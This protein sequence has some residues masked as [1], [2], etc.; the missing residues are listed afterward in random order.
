EPA[1]W[2]IGRTERLR[3]NDGGRGVCKKADR[4]KRHWWRVLPCFFGDDPGWLVGFGRRRRR[5]LLGWRNIE[6]L[7]RAFDRLHYLRLVRLRC[8]PVRGCLL[9]FAV[10]ATGAA[11]RA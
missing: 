2:R 9:Q 7:H 8:S 11:R 6:R 10:R 5:L 4:R 3:F 1:E